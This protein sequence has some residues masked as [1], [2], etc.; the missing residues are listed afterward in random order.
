MLLEVVYEALD[1]AGIPVGSLSNT[2]TSVFCGSFVRDYEQPCMRDPDTTPPYSATGNG[3]AILA[4]RISHAFDFAGTSQTI[5]TGCSASM[6]AVHQACKSL[7]SGESNVGVAAGVGLIFSPNTLVPMANLNILGSD[8]RCYTF[9]ERANGYGRGEGTGV[10][11]LKRLKDAI[12]ANDTIR[13]V[14]RATAS[15]QDGHTQGITLPSQARQVQN[16]SD[17]YRNSGLDITRTAYMECHGTGTQVGDVKE[18]QAAAELFCKHRTSENPLIIGSV[19]TNIGHLEGSAGVAGLIKGILVVERGFIPKHLNFNSPNPNIDFDRMKLKIATDLTPWPVSGLRRASVNSFG[20]G[21]TNAHVVLD[22]TPH[23]LSERKIAGGHHNTFLFPGDELESR[24]R[25]N[26]QSPRRHLFVFSGHD[27]AGLTR[28]IESQ[29]KYV[30]KNTSTVGFETNYAYTLLSRRSR[31]SWRT[32]IVASTATELYQKLETNCTPKPLRTRCTPKELAFVFCGQGAQWYAMGREL[33]KY[34]TFYSSISTASWYMSSILGS[35]LCF[36]DELHRGKELSQISDPQISQPATTAIQVALV[37]LLFS[38]GIV[39]TSVVGHSSGEIAAAYAAGAITREDAWKIAYFRGQ[40]VSQISNLKPEIQGGMLAV[41]LSEEGAR[42][43]IAEANVSSVDVACING[44][45]SVTLSGDANGIFVLH[46]FF[47]SRGHRATKVNV[48]TAYHSRHM[49]VIEGIYRDS[50]KDLGPPLAT[51][52]PVAF[53]SSVFGRQVSLSELGP[54]YWVKNLVQPVQFYQAAA[55]LM[56]TT[57]PDSLLEAL[58]N[59]WAQGFSFELNW[60]LTNPNTEDKPCHLVDVPSYPFDHSKKYWHESH[61]SS[62]NRFRSHGREDI[63]GAPLENSTPQDPRWRGFFRVQENPWLEDHVIQRSIIYPAGGMIAMAVEAAKQLADHSRKILGYEVTN[64]KIVKPMLIPTS[65]QGLEH[66]LSAH[67]LDEDDEDFQK[68]NSTYKFSILSKPTDELEQRLG[69]NAQRQACRYV[70][71]LCHTPLNPRQFYETL[72]V[73]GM[74]YGPQFRNLVEIQRGDASAHAVIQI[75]DTKAQMPFKFE[76]DYIIHPATLDTMLQTVIPLGEDR[77]AML[78]CSAGRIFVSATPPKGAGSRFRG[79]TTA[80]KTASRG[81]MAD[82]TMFDEELRAPA[83]VFE[84]LLFK[85]ASNQ[86]TPGSGGFLPSHRNLCSE[87]VW[88]Q[89]ASSIASLGF[90]FPS[91][92]QG[93]V[94]LASHKNPALSIL[95]HVPHDPNSR[96]HDGMNFSNAGIEHLDAVAEA[97][98][99]TRLILNNLTAGYETPRFSRCIVSGANSEK[100]LQ[101]IR[102]LK[103]TGPGFDRIQHTGT[104]SDNDKHGL[105]FCSVDEQMSVDSLTPCF[106]RVDDSGWL[107]VL[108]KMGGMIDSAQYEAL[109]LVMQAA[110]FQVDNASAK[111]GSSLSAQ[112]MPRQSHLEV[113]PAMKRDKLTVLLPH[114]MSTFVAKLKSTLRPILEQQLALDVHEIN[115]NSVTN[116]KEQSD[117]FVLSL[118]EVDIP[119]ITTL[120][121]QLFKLLHGLLTGSRGVFWLT[122]GGQVD[123]TDPERSAF[124]GL[125]RTLRSEQC[126]RKIVTLDIGSD[127]HGPSGNN[128]SRVPETLINSIVHIVKSNFKTTAVN[129]GLLSSPEDAEFAYSNGRL[130]IPRLM[131]LETLNRI[132]EQ[133]PL[134]KQTPLLAKGRAMKLDMASLQAADG[135]RFVEDVEA[136]HSGLLPNEIR[137]AVV[138]TNL[139]PEDI[140]HATSGIPTQLVGTDVFGHVVETGIGAVGFQKGNYV[141]AR[142]RGTLKTHVIV[143]AS[144][145]RRVESPGDWQGSCPTAFATA[146][147]ALNTSRR[148]MKGDFVLVYGVSSAYGQAAIQVAL[149]LGGNVLAACLAEDEKTMAREQ[150]KIPSSHI[151]DARSTSDEFETRVLDITQRFGVD[152]VFD[153][154]SCHIEQAFVCVAECGRVI[155]VAQKGC[156]TPSPPLADKNVSF[157]TVDINLLEARRPNEAQRL[158]LDIDKILKLISGLDAMRCTIEHNMCGLQKALSEASTNP[159]VGPHLVFTESDAGANLVNTVVQSTSEAAL[160]PSGTYLLIG[161]FGGLGRSIAEHLVKCGAK[162]IAFFSRSGASS[163]VAKAFITKLHASGVHAR[164]FATDICNGEQLAVSIKKVQA[165]M[166]PIRGAIQCAGV[167]DDV[168]FPSMDYDR[169]QNAFEPKAVGSS[170]LHQQLPKDMDF[171]VFLSSSSGIIGNRGQAN[172][173]AGNCYQDALARHRSSLGMHSVSI[174][175]GLVLGAG[176]VAENEGLLDAMKA[177]GFIGIRIQ[178]ALSILDRAMALPG[179]ET[180]LNVPAQIVTTVGT[181]GLTIQNQPSDPFWTRTALFRYLNQVDAPPH[182]LNSAARQAAGQDLRSAIRIAPTPEEAA[183]AV[184]TALIATV[185]RRKGMVSDDFDRHQSLGSYGID[186]LDSIFVLGWIA[187]ETGVTVQTVEGVT[188]AELSQDIARRAVTAEEETR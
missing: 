168:A 115:I 133:G 3:I 22:D 35:S 109:Q 54:E 177:S 144:K 97:L 154:T 61:L 137:I 121:P 57:I 31:L 174:D 26:A 71:K 95:Y 127:L 167:V 184:C 88:K 151:L 77:G 10:L 69:T 16:M 15:N 42:N 160:S 140:I 29:A 126:K 170:N 74:T 87:I 141:V 36:W 30:A 59:L 138:G 114:P 119:L 102:M 142:T 24:T 143:D 100:V 149:A 123:C 1:S 55:V 11:I 116:F 66:M 41:A 124:L 171:F 4:N 179:S 73:I 6:I 105:V 62:A 18:T 125:A 187:R 43:G 98:K 146:M 63:I 103:E 108:S 39:P 131:P 112:K 166:P 23:F 182:G 70:Q 161:G 145:V 107:I 20:F 5:D 37:D 65:T 150:F 162:H 183:Q 188:I 159:F 99:I 156:R 56:E 152:A 181:G 169:W 8:G 81:A 185:A 132:I 153:P 130:L 118:V 19:K 158:A 82:I 90:D 134:V 38:A 173:S 85:S 122:Q 60:P 28:V 48:S 68:S 84:D 12:A 76:F 164:A 33:L 92:I 120:G 86:I 104:V 165:V 96:H 25:T 34:Q 58:G 101:H 175:L 180:S 79:F 49:Q 51:S 111:T 93:I 44:P 155:R 14:I 75:P 136:F 52:R 67:I 148:I 13:A 27:E 139:L 7:L 83:V 147:Y 80:R 2:A 89:D 21:G 91:S 72:D 128:S 178:D 46:D 106:Q 172:Y 113:T 186:S 78:P 110:G 94:D 50:L 17:I 47:R 53:F 176:M 32:F 135:P 45:S 64:F 163:K 157:E 129:K 9:D 117:G 40:A